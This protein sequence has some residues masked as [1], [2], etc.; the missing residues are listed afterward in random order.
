MASSVGR[1][2]SLRFKF[3][4]ALAL[5]STV[6]M[7]MVMLLLEQRLR[8]TLVR[9]SID[10]GLAAARGLAFN[11]EDPL[12]TGD[13]LA[14]FSA[15][16]NAA[17]APG[18]VFAAILDRNG[19]VRADTAVERVGSAYRPPAASQ[20]VNA[21]AGYLVTRAAMS[22]GGTLLDLEVPIVT[23][24]E[25]SLKIGTIHLGLSEAKIAEDIR[26]MRL[27]LAGLALL[28]LLLGTA[29]AALLAG[30]MVGPIT[31]LVR[32][33]R[34][35]GEGQ[36]DQRIDLQRSDELGVLTSAFND[37]AASLREKEFIK[38]TFERYVSK[39]LAEQIL[40]RRSELRLGG[41][42][43]DVTV[44]FSD[45][46]RFTTLAERLPPEQVVDLLNGYFTR[47][48]QVV[49]RHEGM[50]DKLIGD[51]VMALFGAPIT[52]GDEPLRAVRCALEMQREGAVFNREC[53]AR[54]LP[55]LPM[56]IGI[57]TGP[58]I[59]GNIGSTARMEYTV[60][61]DEV[62]IA[63]RL[64]GIAG[65]GEVLISARTYAAIAGAVKVTPLEPIQLKGKA[66]R[67]DVYRV[68]ALSENE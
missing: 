6:L 58:V 10:K 41:E 49:S 47:M 28:A 23:I 20:P 1:F 56:G 57:N 8:E 7:A 37:M 60:I 2:R 44:L 30:L 42:L 65:P 12:L 59:A 3:A 27:H 26:A 54:G 48:I 19:V 18:I 5:F 51:S 34:A 66:A 38:N 68:D 13:D 50:V 64:Q 22:D 9:E 35:I 52:L 32:G 4:L 16:Q 61:G 21:P 63:A 45:I 55:P 24:A 15:V 17:R 62:N 33:V 53:E 46:R 11:V 31:A 14:L 25:P 40:Q 39:P 67:V 36:L 43:R 29:G